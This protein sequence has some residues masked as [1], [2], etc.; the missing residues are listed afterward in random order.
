MCENCYEL[1]P[2]TVAVVIIADVLLTLG[3]ILV[4]YVRARKRKSAGAKPKK[5]KEV[6]STKWPPTTFSS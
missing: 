1:D 3:V 6:L 2:V 4:V 5:G